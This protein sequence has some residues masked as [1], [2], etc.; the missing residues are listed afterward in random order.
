[1]AWKRSLVLP[2]KNVDTLETAIC[3]GVQFC[4]TMYHTRTTSTLILH[5]R[6]VIFV[7]IQLSRSID[8]LIICYP[9]QKAF[10]GYLQDASVKR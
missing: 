3:F 1:M 2:P 4:D 5:V 10:K 6:F 9:Q 7:I 8:L